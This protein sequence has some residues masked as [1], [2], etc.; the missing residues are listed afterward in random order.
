LETILKI[1]R[2][3]GWWNRKVPIVRI[4][5][6]AGVVVCGFYVWAIYGDLIGSVAW[7]IRHQRMAS[8]RG[9]SLQVPWFWKEE[10]WANYNKFE[11][12]RSYGAVAFNSF[13]TVRY[14]NSAPDDVQRKVDTLSKIYA[15]ISQQSGSFYG[16]YEGDDF[17]KTHYACLEN[18]ASSSSVIFVTCFSRDGRWMVSMT[19]LQQ[20]RSEFE[21]ILRGVAS[22]GNPS[23]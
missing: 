21:M 6:I 19:G 8:F 11:L 5:V 20:S 23:K 16:D 2:S 18:G 17:I 3:D 13:V 15:R 9:Q 12:T 1:G 10:K 7:G 22:M 4:S 14:E